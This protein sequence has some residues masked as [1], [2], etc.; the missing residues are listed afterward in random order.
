MQRIVIADAG[1]VIALA[2]VEQLDLLPRLFGALCVTAQVAQELTSGGEFPES[3]A[4]RAAMLG[5]WLTTLDHRTLAAD[6]LN[7]SIRDCMNLYQ[8]DL[9]EASAI[10]FAKQVQGEGGRSLLL[11]DDFRGRAAVQ[12][13]GLAM[14]GTAGLLLLAKQVGAVKDVKPLLLAMRQG[15]YF[16]SERLIEATIRQA[17]E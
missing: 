3:A 12:H 4:I 15:G 7:E 9:G 16:L 10:A 6:A 8:I 17:N 14:V 11:I 1:P 13:V 2:R 5:P